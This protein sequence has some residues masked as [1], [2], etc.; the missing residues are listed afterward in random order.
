MCEYDDVD[1][2]YWSE[3]AAGVNGCGPDPELEYQ[4]ATPSSDETTDNQRAGGADNQAS[5]VYLG[6]TNASSQPPQDCYLNFDTGD[7]ATAYQDIALVDLASIPPQDSNDVAGVS[8]VPG[9]DA[10]LSTA[11]HPE[12]PAPTLP[13]GES[14]A[15]SH[16]EPVGST[17]H[18]EHPNCDQGATVVGARSESADAEKVSQS[19]SGKVECVVPERDARIVVTIV[20]EGKLGLGLKTS[21]TDGPS[22]SKVAADSPAMKVGGRS[23]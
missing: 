18:P 14:V 23:A 7:S 16:S 10:D 21:P 20:R 19:A 3:I 13:A 2:N 12:Q 17:Q 8:T 6:V 9:C 22:V 11:P 15:T 4:L 5:D 1:R